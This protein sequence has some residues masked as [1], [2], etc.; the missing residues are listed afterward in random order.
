MTKSSKRSQYNAKNH[1][2]RGLHL[3]YL[4]SREL[5]SVISPTADADDLTENAVALISTMD[6]T[7]STSFVEMDLETQQ[8]QQAANPVVVEA[9]SNPQAA[10]NNTKSQAFSATDLQVRVKSTTSNKMD[11]SWNDLGAESYTVRYRFGDS[12]GPWTTKV[13]KGKTNLSISVKTNRVYDIYVTPQ[14]MEDK[15][16]YECGGALSKLAVKVVN[17]TDNS[18]SFRI[19]NTAYG[20]SEGCGVLGV[21]TQN[22]K[23]YT[24]YEVYPENSDYTGTLSYTYEGDILT[25]KGLTSN[26]K[27]NFQFAQAA[28]QTSTRSL[29]SPYTNVSAA[30][31]GYKTT[32]IV[33]N[34]LDDSVNNDKYTSL[35]EAIQKAANGAVI[36]FANN[37]K[38]QT[39]NLSSTLVINKNITIDASSLYDAQNNIPGLTLKTIRKD[40][41]YND[42]Y[43]IIVCSPN[44]TI[45]GIQFTSASGI[46]GCGIYSWNVSGLVNIQ[47]CHFRNLKVGIGAGG[48]SSTISSTILNIDNCTISY[49]SYIGL[50]NYN[51]SGSRMNVT[52]CEI[53]YCDN[54]AIANRDSCSMYISNTN[55]SGNRGVCDNLGT[56]EFDRCTF[57]YTT[58]Y[59]INNSGSST[60][61]YNNC[62]VANNHID[63]GYSC[64]EN[65]DQGC[66]YI[67]HSTFAHNYRTFSND[68]SQFVVVRNSVCAKKSHGNSSV[69]F[70]NCIAFNDSG[71][72]E[73]TFRPTASSACVDAGY[74]GASW[75]EKDLAGN[76]R[77]MGTRSD[78]GCYEFFPVETRTSTSGKTTVYWG[79]A[80]V[81]SYTV[82]YRE[83]GTD[84]WTTKTV[85][86]QT[87]LAISVKNNTFYQVLV[88]PEGMARNEK[89]IILTGSLAKL[90]M[91]VINKTQNSISFQITN[92]A[93][94]EMAFRLGIKSQYQSSSK[95]YDVY[96]GGSGSL[97]SLSYTFERGYSY[98]EGILTIRRLSSNTK[99]DF[100]FAQIEDM[101]IDWYYS[102]SYAIST[103]TKMSVTTTR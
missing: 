63:N 18:I 32:K 24:Y 67:N 21:K 93:M 38:G 48:S 79:N 10:L 42:T 99:Y 23:V 27:Y 6:P 12:D 96:Q 34:A 90:G 11:V 75:T 78:I 49:N 30:T 94:P 70:Y 82:Q 35:R 83:E 26:T 45:K 56:A 33:V 77:L 55:F 2:N 88:T 97:G 29:I 31:T 62:L 95:Y 17:R 22:E 43:S 44:T 4:E 54:C 64:F 102:P 61:T 84:K 52:N 39:I 87:Q 81:A 25:I 28:V 5:L 14:G 3:E 46:S 92:I 85:K 80:G 69:D 13:V 101:S 41:N 71:L 9:P 103:F 100:Q 19:S 16:D 53:Y 20:V 89:N 58:G 59:I 40:P 60:A 65:F 8:V 72:D 76:S 37:L 57:Q 98:G 15:E 91:K 66:I 73:N 74:Y 50:L 1:A 68:G 51:P 7:D 86:N 36:T 47:N